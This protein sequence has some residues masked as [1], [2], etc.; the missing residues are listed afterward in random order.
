MHKARK[1]ILNVFDKIDVLVEIV[2][3]RL[4]FSSQNPVIGQ[5]RESKPTLVILSKTDLADPDKTEH[6]QQYFEKEQNV[7]TLAYHKDDKHKLKQIADLCRKLAPLEPSAIKPINAMIVGIPNVGKST[8]INALAGKNI[9]KVGD[10]PAVTKRQQ[11]INLGNNVILHDTPGMLWPKIENP[12]SAYRL[13]I[14]GS[15]KNTAVEYEDIGFYA[16]EAL[17][18]LY[19]ERLCERYGI[20]DLPSTPLECL[21]LVGFKRGAKQAGGRVN[22]H[23]ASEILIHDLRAGHLGLITLEIPAMIERELILVA[24]KLAEKAAKKALRVKNRR[25]N[26][27]NDKNN[28]GR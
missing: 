11:K 2:D 18:A 1:E 15:I 13:A 14:M 7:K 20:V 5:W 23:K 9:A 22:L 3:A 10:E 6:W 4:P 25:N 19:P 27:E 26:R 17:I 24:E 21:E 28:E 12:D 16:A 8:L